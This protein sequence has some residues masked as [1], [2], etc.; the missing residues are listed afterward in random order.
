VTLAAVVMAAA[1]AVLVYLR[2][3]DAP[4]AARLLP[5]ADAVAFV[6]LRLL[7]LARVFEQAPPVSQA[8]E[9]KEFVAATGF[10]F[11]RDLDYLAIAVHAPGS[12][13]NPA[14]TRGQPGWFGERARYS[15]IFIGRFDAQRV[16]AYFR[17]LATSTDRYR[18]AEIFNIPSDGRTVRV[19]IVGVDTVAVSNVEDPAVVRQMIDRY[20]AAARPRTGPSVVREYYE[21]VPLGCV[22][23]VIGRIPASPATKLSLPAMEVAAG[24]LAG[25]AVVASARYLGGVHLRIDAFTPA[26]SNAR[27]LLE[28]AQSFLTIFRSLQASVASGAD[29]DVKAFFDSIKVEQEKDRVRLTATIPQGFIQK[30]L[31][32][33]PP[34]L[35]SPEPSVPAGEKKPVPP[36]K[37]PSRKR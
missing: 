2:K 31:R 20:R 19:A 24:S 35:T 27:N 29:P 34:G 25:A 22:A 6:N 11:E 8:P 30:A 37:P 26:E 17:K 5:E 13:F 33:P 21:R 18:D 32:E 4:E 9:Y 28:S 10:Q 7:R 16:T 12:E 23:W 3:R 15:E 1:I 36:A 14:P